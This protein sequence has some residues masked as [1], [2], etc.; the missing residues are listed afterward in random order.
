MKPFAKLGVVFLSCAL[1]L[2]ASAQK[3]RKNNAAAKPAPAAESQAA[4]AAVQPEYPENLFEGMKYRVVGPFRGGRVEAVAGDPKNPNTYYFG[5]VSGGVWKTTDGGATWGPLTDKYDIWSVGAI[6]VAP[7]APNVIYVGSGEAC[8]RGNITYGNGVWKSVDSGRTWKNM[9]L[10]DTRQIG[11]VAVNP[12]N[13]DIVFVAALGHA[14][15]PNPDRGVYRSTDGGNNW[16]KVLFKDDNTGAIDISIDQNNP[17][18]IYAAM[19]QVYRKPW[20]FSS[21]GPGSG[22]YKSTDGGNTWKE[23]TGNGFPKGTLGR[24]GVAVSPANSD[25]VYANVEAK[26]GGVFSSNDGGE[27]WTKLTG[28]SNFTQRAWY[29]MHIFADPKNVDGVYVLNVSAFHST[30]GGKSWQPFRPPH[31]DNHALWIDPNNPD[32]IIE[33]N[34]GG[35]TIT[36]DGGK[37]WSTQ[38]NQ[39][40]AQFYHV[41]TDNKFHYTIYGAQQDNSTI[42]IAS[43]TDGGPID[44][45]DWYPVGGGES[46]YVVPYLP[47]PNIVFAGSYDGL[48]TKFNKET[49]VEEDINPWPDNP[50]GWG[51]GDLKYRFQWT[52]PI[53]ASPEDPNTLYMGANV[54][55]RTTDMGQHWTAISPDLTRNDKSKQASSG[56]PLTQDNTSI[57]YYDT[58]FTIAESSVT[59][60]VIWAGSDDG[61]IH[62]TRDAGGH[63]DNVTPKE[64]PEW[65]TVSL[66]DA[67]PLDAGTAYVAVDRHRLDDLTP[68]IFKTSDYGKTWTKLVNGIPEGSFVHVVRQD[69]KDRNLLFAGTETGVFVSWNDGAKWQPLKLNLPAV[70]IHDL[71]IKDD[72]L[73]LATHGRSFWVLDDIE[74]LRQMSQQVATADVFFYKPGESFR[75]RGG[76]GFFG[77]GGGGGNP[78]V[79]VNPPGPVVLEYFLKTAPKPNE[80]VKLDILDQ[81][82][83]VIRKYSSK[84]PATARRGE[85]EEESFRPAPNNRLPAKEGLNLFTWDLRTEAPANVPGLSQWGGR[86]SG[87][88]VPP[89]AYQARLTVA[90]K[91]YTVPIDVKADPRLKINSDDYMK[92]Y[93]L[94]SKI[95][96]S[97]DAANRA[98]N[99]MRDVLDQ[100]KAF[101]DRYKDN[102]QAKEV[103]AQGDAL[104]KKITPVEEEIVQDKSHASEDPLNFPIRV[105]NKLLLLSE[106]VSSAEGAPTQQSYEVYDELNKQLEASLAKWKEIQSSD[107][108]AFNSAV[109]K[110]NLPAVVPGNGAE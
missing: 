67:S 15:G 62:V 17:Q 64:M 59:K 103:I 86:P 85:Q 9:G 23:I 2:G 97:V 4:P 108:A 39:P 18:I 74:P 41:A 80:E 68:Y 78:T 93:D 94:E 47:D 82:G 51:A 105:N 28:S 6:A 61:M 70:P 16:Q 3:S 53:A 92:Q 106:T 101:K 109:Q 77:G 89:G 49:G 14:F 84:P 13:P 12:T 48:I 46:G 99:Q 19:Y 52:S 76:R 91:E 69:P 20:M 98:V 54:V 42:A 100:L 38:L 58:V 10:K 5:A 37:N 57:E 56:G 96:Q 36:T 8:L 87:A 11:R 25:R 110:A 88:T 102:A 40:T 27:H 32:R 30:D 65:G 60:G 33:G 1:V 90:G 72:D 34:D 107:V 95:N 45:T 83:K 75:G 44:R 63:W 43:S 81:Q 22:L 50:M 29:Y 66:I 79:G 35:A 7:S 31:G 24:I 104:E 73:V 55:F 26:E 21:G 71:V